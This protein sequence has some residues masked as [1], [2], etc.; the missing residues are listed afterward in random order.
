MTPQRRG[1]MPCFPLW[2]IDYEWGQWNSEMGMRNTKVRETLSTNSFLP[3][4]GE[5]YTFGRVEHDCRWG[6][7][8]SCSPEIKSPTS[9][10]SLK[11]QESSRNIYTSA[12]LTMPKPLTVWI[13][14]K[15]GKFLKRWKYQTTLPAS[16]ETS[17]QDQKQQVRT[18]HGTADW[19]KI[20]KG[21]CQ[22]CM[23]SS[24]L[25]NLHAEYIIQNAGLGE[26][27]A[28]IKISRR[29]IRNLRYAD[30]TTVKV[31]NEE[32]LKN[33]LMRVKEEWKSWFK[34]QYSKH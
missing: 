23:L 9:I 6:S 28:R 20:G 1:L 2:T 26:S 8:A 19:F 24:C 10:R 22:G 5:P 34:I 27:Q 25:F 31:E 11:K 7:H 14:T 29:N 18:S 17:M 13:T 30:D 12:L 16:W 15:S 4:D 32:K 33:L 21:V 3:G